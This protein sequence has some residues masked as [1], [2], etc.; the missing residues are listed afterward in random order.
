MARDGAARG[1]AR[2]SPFLGYRPSFAPTPFPAVICASVNDAIVH[3]IPDGYRL[4][5]GDLVSIDCG[6]NWTAGPATRRSASP[7]ARRARPTSADR[8]HRAGA[9][10][11]HRGGRRR[12]PHRRHRPRHR[13]GVPRGRVRDPG[14]TSAATASAAS[15]HE[16]PRVPNEGRPGRGHAAAPRPG[17]GDRADVHGRRRRRVPHRR[18]TAGP[19]ARSTAAEPPTRTHRG[20]HRRTAPAS[21]PP[22]HPRPP[23]PRAVVPPP[24]PQGPGRYPQGGTGGRDGTRKRRAAHPPPPSPTPATPER[25]P[26]QPPPHLAPRFRT[27][28]PKRIVSSLA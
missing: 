23:L 10:R 17:P 26:G 25:R 15:M 13:H 21:S 8:D 1:R 5:D 4:R 12:Q 19:C 9:G 6:A 16:D 14:R 22:D 27:C 18:A 2:R 11:G 3:G 24:V 20:D 28:P 7:S